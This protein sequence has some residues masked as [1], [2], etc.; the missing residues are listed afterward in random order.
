MT[1][2]SS[3]PSFP[4]AWGIFG[5]YIAI[6]LGAGLILGIINEFTGLDN[7]PLTNFIGYTISGILILWFVWLKKKSTEPGESFI[8]FGTM[9]VSLSLLLLILTVTTGIA[10]DPISNIIPMPDIIEQVFELILE[11]STYNLVLLV[12]IGPIIEEMLL[13]GIIL[14]GFLRRYSPLKS[15]FWSSLIFGLLHLNPWQFIGA[16]IIGLLMGY[17]YWKTRSLIACI[18]IHMVNNGIGYIISYLYGSEIMTISELFDNRRDYLIVYFS[19]I[20]ITLLLFLALH[21]VLSKQKKIA[22]KNSG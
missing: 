22:W 4:Q 11:K 13:R 16:F 17:I 6:S 15:I 8:H 7:L 12:I 10:I 2:A 14:D 20:G 1:N 3:Y 5:L 21:Q 9:P 19:S 18:F